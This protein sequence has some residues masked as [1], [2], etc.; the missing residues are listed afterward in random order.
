MTK[1]KFKG[2]I[3][4]FKSCCIHK[5]SYRFFKFQ[6]QFDHEGQGQGHQFSNPS[7]TFR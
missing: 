4:W 1:L 2:K 6:E 5:E 3:P 7:E